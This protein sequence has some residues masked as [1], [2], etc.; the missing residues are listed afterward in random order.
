MDELYANEKRTEFTENNVIV[1]TDRAPY[2]GEQE[3]AT[4]TSRGPH[5]TSRVGM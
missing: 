1:M 2:Y 4:N 5:V 3:V